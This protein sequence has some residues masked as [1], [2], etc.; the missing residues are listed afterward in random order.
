MSNIVL[1]G[2]LD[3]KNST[4]VSMASAFEKLGY[5]ILPVNYRAI[6]SNKGY[7]FFTEYL[8]YLINKHSPELVLFSKCNGIKTDI[9]AECT[10]RTK[11]WLWNMDAKPTIEK[12]PEVIEHA[13]NCNFSS[14]T[15]DT[16]RDWFKSLGVDNCKTIVEGID[17]NKYFPID[18]DENHE[19]PE[20][21]LIGSRTE[22]RN[23]FLVYLQTRGLDAKFYG[24]GYTSEVYPA[25]FR[26]ICANTK[27]MLSMNIWNGIPKYFSDRIARYLA[28]N[29]SVIHYDPTMSLEEYFQNGKHLLYART[30]EDIV[31][32][33]L[34]TADELR[35]AIANN[36]YFHVVDNYTW[37]KVI[38]KILG[39]TDI[40]FD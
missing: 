34:T 17:T 40:H 4:N 10:K 30:K 24:P 26:Q 16:T 8:L 20:I 7:S 25:E 13:K 29:T 19:S 36:G 3:N 39:H 14:C 9:V 11:T 1:V 32:L 21:A 27:F 33:V 23:K 28:C 15:S 5:K 2:V 6:I 31:D 12:C 38:P 35:T 37:E 22:E 18:K